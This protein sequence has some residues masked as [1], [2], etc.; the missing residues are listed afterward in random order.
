MT[1]LIVADLHLDFWLRAGRDPLAALAPEDWAGL[2][3]LIIAGDLSNKPKVR[4]KHAIRHLSRYIDPGRL[5]IVPG[6]HDYYDHVLDGDDRLAAIAAEEGAKL[7]QKS[8]VVVGATRFLCC[9]LW[10]DF[11]LHGQPAHAQDLARA[12]MN[13]YRYIRHAG[14]GYSKIRPVET[15]MIHCEHRAWLESQ[16]AQPFAGRTVVVTHHAPHPDM[17]GAQ[18]ADMDPVYGSNLIGVIDRFQPDGWIFGHTHHRVEGREGRTVIR[19]V[20]LGYPQQVPPCEEAAILM[21]GSIAS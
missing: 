4:W 6:N 19:N 1:T 7:A 16:L 15:A 21:R 13:D 8:A 11:E 9:T 10:T 5:Y 12:Q 17:I 20:S 14:V 18:R 2:E 3:A